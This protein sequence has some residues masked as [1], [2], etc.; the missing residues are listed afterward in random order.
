MKKPYEKPA[1]VMER[2]DTGEIICSDPDSEFCKSFLREAEEAQKDPVPVCTLLCGR[3][4]CILE[5]DL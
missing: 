3:T 1:F 2:F 5:N 4:G